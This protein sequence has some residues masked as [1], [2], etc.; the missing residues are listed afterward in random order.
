M[1][2]GQG[3]GC[4]GQDQSDNGLDWGI[5]TVRG[6]ATAAQFPWV[7]SGTGGPRSQ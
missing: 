1:Q 2:A 3:L 7:L 4:R 5:P 6:I